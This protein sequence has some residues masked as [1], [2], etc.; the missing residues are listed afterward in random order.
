MIGHSPEKAVESIR[1]CGYSEYSYYLATD[2]ETKIM[3]CRIYIQLLHHFKVTDP[4]LLNEPSMTIF[5]LGLNESLHVLT[6]IA[7]G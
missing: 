7:A 6:F 4:P 5:L 2:V 1:L 3:F